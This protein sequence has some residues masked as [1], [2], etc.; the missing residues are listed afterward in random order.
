[1]SAPA[2][3]IGPGT[4]VAVRTKDLVAWFAPP[5]GVDPSVLIRSLVLAAGRTPGLPVDRLE[6]LLAS[7]PGLSLAV[8][9]LGREFGRAWVCGTAA[10]TIDGPDERAEVQA[11]PGVAAQRT[12]PLPRYAVRLGD[13]AVTDTWSHLIEGAVPA[14]GIAVVW[15]PSEHPQMPVRPV[16][17]AHGPPTGA[18]PAVPRPRF[19]VVSL[20]AEEPAAAGAPLP[21]A[22]K[23]SDDDDHPQVEVAGLRCG[24]GHFNHPYAAN[25][26]WCGLS[27]IQVSHVMVKQPRPPLGVLVVDGQASFTLDADYVLG[28]QPHVRPEVDGHKVREIV[29]SADRAISRAHAAVRLVDWDVVVEDLGSGIGTWVQQRGQ[30]PFQLPPGHPVPLAPGAVVHL[31]P[32]RLTYHSHFV[33]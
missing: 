7:A 15:D 21:I 17:T 20:L 13:A 18:Q 12:F 8:V 30:L 11:G 29:L 24:R 28:R 25:C 3:R 19:E 1:M 5:S 2:V 16:A 4:G 10:V 27:M 14:G 6:E 23:E 33:R 32:H 22:G 26:A 9:A 31:G